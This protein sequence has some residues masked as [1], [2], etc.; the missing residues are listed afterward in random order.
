GRWQQLTGAVMAK[1]VEDTT[2][3]LYNPLVSANE[4]GG[5]PGVAAVSLE[6]F[7][8]LL[9]RRGERW[10]RTLNA[11]STHDTKRGEDVRA[12]IHVLSEIPDEWARRVERWHV[13]NRA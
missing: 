3:Y 13:W 4:V 9:A 12:R 7:H 2:F 6:D 1:G 10:P 5:D 8:R 11:S